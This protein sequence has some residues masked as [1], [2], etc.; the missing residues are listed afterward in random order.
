MPAPG[1]TQSRPALPRPPLD[2][3]L[4]FTV[5]GLSTAAVYAVIASG[6][7]L[8]YTTT[9]IFNFAHGAVGMLSAFM[10][11]EVHVNRGL[12]TPLSLLIVLGVFAPLFGVLLEAVVMRGLYGTSEA[13]KLVVSISLLAGMISVA[14]WVWPPA[15]RSL[16][17]FYGDKT[18]IKVFSTAVTYHE[19]ITMLVAIVVALG[20]RSL[21]YGT[22][23][24]IAMRAS[25]DDRAL[26][27][28]NGARPA[29]VAMLAWAIGAVLA[30][31]GGILIAPSSGLSAPTLS[32]L[33]VNAYAAAIFGRLSRLPLTFVGAV[34]LGLADGYLAGYT[35]QNSQFLAGLRLAAPA[36]LLF[37]VLLV[38]PNPRL[39][40]RVR[41]REFFPAPSWSAA[42][43]FGAITVAIGL[44]LATT[45]SSADATIYV[46]IFPIAIFALSLVPLTGFA[47]Q[48]SLCQL[49]FAAIGA[50]VWA[51]WGTHGNPLVM[52][53]AAVVAGVVGGLIALPALRLSGIYLALATAGFAVALDNWI[54][55][56]PPIKV[57]GL[58]TLNLFQ[59]GQ[60][61]AAPLKVF[62]Y[63]FDTADRA[64]VL[65]SVVLALMTLVVVWIRR[66]SFGRRLLAMKDS[67]A[68][69]A[70]L[71]M[72]LI[73]AKT[74][75]FAISAAMAGLGGALYASELQSIVNDRFSFISGLPIFTLAVIG[76]I[77]FVGTG[78]FSGLSLGGGLPL[79][80]TLGVFWTNLSGVLPGLAGI[81]LGRN[82][83]GAISDMRDAFGRAWRDKRIFGALIGGEVLI[84]V[85]RVA[86]VY[87]NWPYVML[88][89]LWALAW[90][91]SVA[92]ADRVGQMRSAA[93]QRAKQGA[94][95]W[96]GVTEPWD[97]ADLLE[98]D[99]RLAW[100]EEEQAH[101]PV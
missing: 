56:L 76:G 8:T 39:R 29:R 42:L 75:I 22:R 7:V 57:F 38:I 15:N 58:F 79:L 1:G 62:G 86:T 63:S 97:A 93:P 95:E 100:T 99:R 81:G 73:G 49:S 6:L 67:E 54:W 96:L 87:R 33:I 89:G 60:T 5:I 94:L 51:Q 36:I 10:Y 52:L 40:G 31:I 14:N 30:A 48:I 12:S 61:S 69:C 3:F 41:T 37:L 2:K 98:I 92:A 20:L 32:L 27:T 85:L 72:R 45:L 70:T 82:P 35:P 16:S 4:T 90:L 26:A 68:A 24:G 64:M 101:A 28:L 9:G 84:W 83:N 13:T 17:E 21:L 11:W 66:S 65:L 44:V 25:V 74:A 23:I 53:A 43:T 34:V 80:G 55:T 19:L 91:L 59:T 71:G 18:P 46:N 88:A 78:M 77:A 47:G 50:V